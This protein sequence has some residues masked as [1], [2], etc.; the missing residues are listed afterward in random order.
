MVGEEAVV[1]RLERQCWGPTLSGSPGVT[2]LALRPFYS[3]CL[4]EVAADGAVPRGIALVG[5]RK[6]LGLRPGFIPRCLLNAY[7]V[8]G[9]EDSESKR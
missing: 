5:K 3:P 1:G 7:G 8:L 9:I 6:G 2:S 4:K